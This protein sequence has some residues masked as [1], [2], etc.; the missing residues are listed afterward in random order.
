MCKYC[1]RLKELKDL[2]EKRLLALVR[3][4][5]RRAEKAD[6]ILSD[7]LDVFS[8]SFRFPVMYDVQLLHEE[9]EK[10]KRGMKGGV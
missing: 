9:I 6:D 10:F 2:D 5:K 1:K 8:Y 7:V 3:M 4:W